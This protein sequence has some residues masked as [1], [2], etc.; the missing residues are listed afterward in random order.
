MSKIAK[1]LKKAQE[2][3]GGQPQAPG[4]LK[5]ENR[6]ASQSDGVV[7]PSYKTT[8][9]Q[10][11]SEEHMELHRLL[12]S[13][14]AQHV[15]DAFNILRAR[16]LHSTRGRNQNA[17]MITSPGRGE[18]KTTVATNLAISIAKDAR[19]TAL[20]VDANLRWPAV[21]KTLGVCREE[22]GGLEELLLGDME[23]PEVM[24]NPGIDKL[25][26]LPTCGSVRHSADLI[27]SPRMQQTVREMKSRYPDRYV[28]FDCPH[29]LGMPD[30]LVFSTY[31]DGVI[32][33]V[34]DGRTKKSDIKDALDALGDANVM[35]IVLNRNMDS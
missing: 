6:G 12:G 16:L 1:A 32:L 20:L 35:G 25:V 30:T 10:E 24:V 5:P 26:V 27:A 11:S 4:L 18:G 8:Q 13:G 23:L 28:I 14:S 22:E 3:R 2:E 17:I 15:L 33:V 9:V 21:S 7:R 31:V 29:V 34:E 19:Q